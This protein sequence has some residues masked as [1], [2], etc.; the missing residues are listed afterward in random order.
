MNAQFK[1][2]ILFL[3]KVAFSLLTGFLVAFPLIAFGRHFF[4]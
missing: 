4:I 2:W 3:L 1:D